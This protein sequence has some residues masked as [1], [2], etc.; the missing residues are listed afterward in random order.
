MTARKLG[1]YAWNEMLTKGHQSTAQARE[2]L[3]RLLE[4]D[5][6]PQTRAM[7]VAKIAVRLG[8]I[9]QVL[10]EIEQVTRLKD[11]AGRG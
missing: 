4:D 9:E 11:A 3:R 7:L 2:A 8:E 5:P 6:G 1:G 10:S